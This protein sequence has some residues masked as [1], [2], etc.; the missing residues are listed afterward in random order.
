MRLEYGSSLVENQ[1]IL[2]L[3]FP[4]ASA[5]KPTANEFNA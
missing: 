3:F 2:L 4:F 1:H 5:M